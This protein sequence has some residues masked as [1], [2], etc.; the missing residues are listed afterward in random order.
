[1]PSWGALLRELN[2]LKKEHKAGGETSP[3]DV[4]RRKYLA[5]ARLQTKRAVIL[6]ASKWTQPQQDLT[7]DVI[8][9]TD[10]DIQGFMEVLHGVKEKELDVVLHSPGGSIEAAEAIVSYLR[11]R[12]DHIRVIVPYAAMSAASM[13]SCAADRIVMGKHSFLGPTDPQ[14]ILQTSLGVRFVAAQSV[15]EQFETAKQE[16]QDPRLL[17]AWLPMLNQYGPELLVRCKKAS[18]LSESL[19]KRWLEKYMFKG[20]QDAQQKASTISTWLSEHDQFKSHS[21]HISRDDL[22]AKGLTVD[23]LES[24]QEEQDNFLSIFHSATLTFDGSIGCVKIIENH[25]GNAFIKQTQQI[26]LVQQPVPR[27]PAP[28][29]P[30]SGKPSLPFKK[31]GTNP[32]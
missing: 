27:A 30:S 32:F 19:V 14:L 13:I 7:P 12:F 17:A 29:I 10:E 3:F 15:L 21:R 18:E 31:K 23:K 26:V 28:M 22:Y 20:Q 4:L 16:C 8:S 24:D 2:S 11:S 5:K 25:N 1:M 6:Y 9:I